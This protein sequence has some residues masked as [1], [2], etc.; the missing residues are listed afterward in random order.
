MFKVTTMLSLLGS[1]TGLML[2]QPNTTPEFRQSVQQIQT[3][4]DSQPV[5]DLIAA[6]REAR[7]RRPALPAVVYQPTI[8]PPALVPL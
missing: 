6:L 8:N 4:A 3:T 5:K 7:A 2:D 1:V